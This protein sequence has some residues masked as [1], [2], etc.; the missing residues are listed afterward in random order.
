MTG[1]LQKEDPTM[2]RTKLLFIAAVSAVYSLAA[3]PGRALDYTSDPDHS[4]IL[5]KVKHLGVSTVTGRF[6][7]FTAT[8]DFDPQALKLASVQATIEAA[9]LSTNVAKRD[10]HL[11]SA[12]FLDVAKY[13][14]ITFASREVTSIKDSKFK[15]TGDLSLHGVTHPVVLDGSFGG[16][17]KDP[18]GN[19]RAAF[20]AT[21]TI[22]RKDFGLTWNKTLD[23]GG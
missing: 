6:E 14:T 3:V 21:T 19:E 23:N 12:D 9:S 22:H 5:F 18:W 20:T 4:N 11:R 8:F 17:V 10:D 1:L 7:K 15:L 2:N 13:P 16:A